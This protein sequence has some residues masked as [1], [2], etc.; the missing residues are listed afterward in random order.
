MGYWGRCA[1]TATPA[2]QSCASA[3]EGLSAAGNLNSSRDP[4]IRGPREPETCFQVPGSDDPRRCSIQCPWNGRVTSSGVASRRTRRLLQIWHR[5]HGRWPDQ[6]RAS[7]ASWRGGP[8][9]PNT[10]SPGRYLARG[11]RTLSVH[12][13]FIPPSV[14]DVVASPG[15]TR[16][17]GEILPTVRPGR[18]G[19]RWRRWS[20]P[21]HRPGR[22]S[23][24]RHP[25]FH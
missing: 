22:A 21:C 19:R 15:G 10:G 3:S 4:A 9:R 17:R 6:P 11:G 8:R 20:S 18:P 13:V 5:S 1:G 24:P 12:A 25:K 16:C 7:L 23:P 2:D 14:V